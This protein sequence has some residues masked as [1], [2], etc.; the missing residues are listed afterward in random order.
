M[1]QSGINGRF[2]VHV[3]VYTDSVTAVFFI[4]SGF[5]MQWFLEED[6]RNCRRT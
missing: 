1:I 2:Y 4:R 5:D 3:H 6:F